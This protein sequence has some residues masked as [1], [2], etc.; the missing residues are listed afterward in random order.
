MMVAAGQVGGEFAKGARKVRDGWGFGVEQ[1]F[2][3]MEKTFLSRF[4]RV[5]AVKLFQNIS[6]HPFLNSLS[7]WLFPALFSPVSY[8]LQGNTE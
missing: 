3:T 5:A 2:E 7:L 8:V 4:I 6:H 1:L